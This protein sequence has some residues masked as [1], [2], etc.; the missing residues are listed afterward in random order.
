MSSVRT[1]LGYAGIVGVIG[2]GGALWFMMLPGEDRR[3][4]MMKNLPEASPIRMEETRQRN[5]LLLQAIKEAAE[6]NENVARRFGH[7]RND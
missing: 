6:T 7:S 3:R 1:I 2:V 5:T 4:E